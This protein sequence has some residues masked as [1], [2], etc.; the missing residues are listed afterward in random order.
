MYVYVNICGYVCVCVNVCVCECVY[1]LLT[2]SVPN[3]KLDRGII[4]DHGLCQEGGA[5]G[6]FLDV[7]VCVCIYV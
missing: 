2:C 5:D 4:E 1:V 6:G 7:C 3:L